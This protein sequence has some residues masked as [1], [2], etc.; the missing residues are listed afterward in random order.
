[1]TPDPSVTVALYYDPDGYVEHL[2]PQTRPTAGGPRGLMGRQVA[3]REFLDAY[4]AHGH[5]DTLTAVV[6]D[7]QRAAPLVAAC[8][9]HPSSRTRQRRLRITEERE[10]LGGS[11]SPARV[12]HFPNPPDARFAWSRHATSPT[13]FALCGVTHTLASPGAATALCELVA[14]PFEPFDSLICT[15]REERG[16]HDNNQPAGEPGRAGSQQSKAGGMREQR[17]RC[18]QPDREDIERADA[19]AARHA[20]EFPCRH[21]SHAAQQCRK[22]R[23]AKPCGGNGDRGDEERDNHALGKL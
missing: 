2:G 18:G 13:A 11:G 1:M 7:R 17:E 5:W 21:A 9:D 10:F 8:R 16:S 6:R 23:V 12:L 19:S 14:A 3:G 4:L 22:P 20:T 15:S